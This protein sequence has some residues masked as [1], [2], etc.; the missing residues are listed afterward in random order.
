MPLIRLDISHVSTSLRPIQT[1]AL[2]GQVIFEYGSA[3]SQK[4][5][6]G[7][8]HGAPSIKAL[9]TRVQNFFAKDDT[10]NLLKVTLFSVVATRIRS[11][12]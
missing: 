3:Q 7:T 4:V 1:D 8:R 12:C 6:I 11:T 2:S 5:T 10:E 9:N